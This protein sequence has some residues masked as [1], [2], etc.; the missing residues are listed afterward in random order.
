M[1]KVYRLAKYTDGGTSAGFEFF[2]SKQEAERERRKHDAERTDEDKR[3]GLGLG[4][5]DV[6]EYEATRAGI[7]RLLNQYASHADNG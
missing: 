4:N 7:L 5:V 2:S 1:S 3:L 6:I